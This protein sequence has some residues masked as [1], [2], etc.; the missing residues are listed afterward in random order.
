MQFKST[1][2]AVYPSLAAA[3]IQLTVSVLR[4][5]APFYCSDQKYRIGCELIQF[6]RD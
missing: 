5:C 6:P 3:I 4:L 1:F 2:N